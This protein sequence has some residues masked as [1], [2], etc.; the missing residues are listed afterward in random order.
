MPSQPAPSAPRPEARILVVDDEE[1][2]RRLVGLLLK[3]M[4]GVDA[5]LHQAANAQDATRP[6]PSSPHAPDRAALQAELA[7][8][9]KSMRQIRVKLG[10]GNMSPEGYAR[11]NADLTAKRADIEVKL[12]RLD[13]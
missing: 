6:D 2:I 10:L 4:P 7:E 11:I 5:K 3:R 9:E 13:L 8:I 12:L 1:Q